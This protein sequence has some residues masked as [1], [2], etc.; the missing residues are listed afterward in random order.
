MVGAGRQAKQ[1]LRPPFKLGGVLIVVSPTFF[2]C[3][4]K[5][6]LFPCT[7]PP[8]TPPT[9]YKTLNQRRG[10]K[11]GIVWSAF[12]ACIRT[13]LLFPTPRLSTLSAFGVNWRSTSKISENSL[14]SPR[15]A[16]RAGRLFLGVSFIKCSRL[17]IGIKCAI[18][19]GKY[20]VLMSVSSQC[21]KDLGER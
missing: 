14:T 18:S 17:G 21:R 5:Q 19:A 1:L 10:W 4:P 7:F 9:S 2:G 6:L 20:T 16:T 13:F 11:T 8:S 3:R 15:K 12:G